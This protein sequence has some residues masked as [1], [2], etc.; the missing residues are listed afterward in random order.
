MIVKE[1]ET[2]KRKTREGMDKSRKHR[3]ECTN[4]TVTKKK[5]ASNRQ[6]EK[7]FIHFPNPYPVEVM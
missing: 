5:T 7:A 4:S 2:E 3:R 6:S 1:M